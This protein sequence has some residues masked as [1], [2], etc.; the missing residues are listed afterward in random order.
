MIQKQ[1]ERNKPPSAAADRFFF[2]FLLFDRAKVSDEWAV[3]N[4][5]VCGFLHL[6]IYPHLWTIRSGFMHLIYNCWIIY[7]LDKKKHRKTSTSKTNNEIKWTMKRSWCDREFA[8]YI[9]WL[10]S[11]ITCRK[12]VWTAAN[13]LAKLKKNL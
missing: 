6:F 4:K 2:R 11:S 1:E 13:N 8:I 10:K 12:Y 5:C 7:F 9:V 3:E